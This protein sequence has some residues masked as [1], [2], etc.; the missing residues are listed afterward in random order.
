LS[1]STS[2]PL[3]SRPLVCSTV[4]EI[5][6]IGIDLTQRAKAP[7]FKKWPGKATAAHKAVAKSISKAATDRKATAQTAVAKKTSAEPSGTEMPAKKIVITR[8]TA[9]TATG[10]K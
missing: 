8:A 5:K 2:L 1:S 6:V 4:E 10:K 3:D 9:K 7:L